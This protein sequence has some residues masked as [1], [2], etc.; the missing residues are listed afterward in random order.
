MEE[1]SQGPH[2]K[3]LSLCGLPTD[4]LRMI[5]K[6]IGLKDRLCLELLD[7]RDLETLREPELWYEVDLASMQAL[8]LTEDQLLHLLSRV[9]PEFGG[10][11]SQIRSMAEIFDEVTK[12]FMKNDPIFG[13]S[14]NEISQ[15]LSYLGRD[16]LSVA[17][18][19][20]ERLHHTVPRSWGTS[21]LLVETCTAWFFDQVHRLT[22][23]GPWVWGILVACIRIIG[24]PTGFVK[25]LQA[26]L[27][28]PHRQP[29]QSRKAKIMVSLY[30]SGA[31]KLSPAYLAA[32]TIA[33]SAA[34]FKV[35]FRM[36][37][38]ADP[39]FPAYHLLNLM[40]G[41]AFD[42]SIHVGVLVP[43]THRLVK[44]CSEIFNRV[45]L[46]AETGYSTSE[47]NASLRNI[48]AAA[49]AVARVME[50]PASGAAYRRFANKMLL[51]VELREQMGILAG[52]PDGCEVGA[53]A[54]VACETVVFENLY[55]F[56]PTLL[57]DVQEYLQQPPSNLRLVFRNS[58]LTPVGFALIGELLAAS[59]A[60]CVSFQQADF[61][62]C[63]HVWDPERESAV[64]ASA[65]LQKSTS[66]KALELDFPLASPVVDSVIHFLDKS[67]QGAQVVIHL[68]PHFYAG[69]PERS[70]ELFSKLR[71]LCASERGC[72]VEIVQH[73]RGPGATRV[74]VSETIGSSGDDA[75]LPIQQEIDAQL[76]IG[77]YIGVTNFLILFVYCLLDL[78]LVLADLLALKPFGYLLRR[79]AYLPNQFALRL[80]W[81]PVRATL[82]GRRDY[83]GI[84]LGVCIAYVPFS[85]MVHAFKCFVL[86]LGLCLVRTILW[87]LVA[88]VARV[89]CF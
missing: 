80:L 85:L 10:V 66:L 68:R 4:V 38:H 77:K 57:D 79:P 42:C 36:T 87:Q 56:E 76:R 44:K 67:E 2:T 53:K 39:P 18:L 71:D 45:S 51:L 64:L 73:S 88:R 75:L 84:V 89:M 14:L 30:V 26:R 50:Y 12:S 25:K 72:R 33:L 70:Q 8:N 69:N 21:R 5:L 47:P 83:I 40:R 55:S 52:R 81:R 43:C 27:N 49:L 86:Y 59:A 3:A 11:S 48:L 60:S 41:L 1:R 19:S 34:G 32:C 22:Q 63:R 37:G 17:S 20:L 31:K 15:D 7:K 23:M 9:H 65:A 28:T 82:L 61:P 58:L 54:R 29:P 35:R 24:D 62:F 78:S 16:L 74:G 46:S 6:K 13:R